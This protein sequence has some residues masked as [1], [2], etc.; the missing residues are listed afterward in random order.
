MRI[1]IAGG[2]VGAALIAARLIREGNEVTIVEKDAERCLELDEHLDAKIVQGSAGSVRT[3]REAGLDKAE[4][5]IA[6][7]NSDEINLLCCMIAQADSSV[8]VKVARVR[9]HEF[10]QWERILTRMGLQVDRII[11]PETDIMQRIMRVLDLPGVSDILDFAD[12]A[13]K[14]FGM[15]VNPDSWF[16]GKTVVELD[17]ANPPKDSLIALIFRGQEVIIPHGAQRLEPG[18]HIYICTTRECLD[19]VFAF[20]GIQK[21]KAIQRATIVG[22]RQIGIWVAEELERMGVSVKLIERDPQRCELISTIL[23]KTVVIH[24]DGTDQRTLEE[25]NIEGADAFLALTRDDA[26]NI[27]ASLQARRLGARKIVALVNQPNHLPI[28]RRLGINT[29]ISQR[30]TAV[31]MVLRYVRKG[32]VLSVTTFHEEREEEAEA[33]ELIAGRGSKFVNK[34]LREIRF[35]QGAIVGAIAR[36]DG[37]VCVPRGEATIH[38]GDRVIFFTLESAVPELESAFLAEPERTRGAA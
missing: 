22:G 19:D 17:A 15:N 28:I 38:E 34:K 30:L 23:D 6:E 3:L 35:P 20:M 12:G 21:R 4:M 16:A 36:P 5:L 32:R 29:S 26:D 14:L 10:Q 27:I 1:L 8:K 37:E 25:E 24:D 11:H 33:I 9:T 2:G 18:D 31:D 7:T 13:I